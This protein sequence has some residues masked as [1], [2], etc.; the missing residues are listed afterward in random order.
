MSKLEEIKDFI[1]LKQI[2]DKRET[3][4]YKTKIS[5]DLGLEGDE[6]DQFLDAFSKKFNVDFSDFNFKKYFVEE[7]WDPIR[8]FI[9]TTGII[10]L[11]PITLRDL[12]KSA[13][14]GKWIDPD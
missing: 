6:A 9:Y 11:K 14:I 3:L 5:Q 2:V 12:E 10:K 1:L 7:G 4:T 13:E 8:F